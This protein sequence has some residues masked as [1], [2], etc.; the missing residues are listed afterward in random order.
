MAQEKKK[1]LK[2]RNREE[3]FRE[4]IDKALKTEKKVFIKSNCVSHD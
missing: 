2:V 4:Q 1:N 3:S